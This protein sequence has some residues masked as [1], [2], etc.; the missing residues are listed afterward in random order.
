MATIRGNFSQ[1]LAP[2]LND[3][4]FEWLKEHPE[5]YS[6]FLKVG[7]SKRAYEQDQIIAGLGLA[8]IKPEQENITYDDPEQGGSKRYIHDTYA[9]AFQVSSEML[10]DDEYGKIRQIPKELIKS[11]RQTW[12]QLGA[13]VLNNG[14]ST[15]TVADG[16]SLFNTAHPMVKG[17]GATLSNR[18]NPA[19][20]LSVTALQ[21]LLLQFE[22]MRNEANL[23]MRVS[24]D[25]LWIPPD[26]Q[27]MAGKVLQSQFEPGTG[28]NDINPVQGRLEPCVLHYLTD[29]NNW[30]ISSTEHNY[31]KFWWRRQ[32]T[33]DSTDDFETGGGSKFSMTCRVSAGATDFRG[34]AGSAP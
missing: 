15:V 31:A 8:H 12:E 6:Q 19:A 11:L 9:L 17:D 2:G 13:N 23:R 25:K 5:E 14:F 33:M 34:W 29:T 32:P 22:S 1:L 7:T 26:L 10:D 18:L 30:F 28:N 24:P 20:E 16:L 21:N 27:F 3:V 4:M